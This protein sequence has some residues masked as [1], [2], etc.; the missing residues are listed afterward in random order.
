MSPANKLK[1]C[2]RSFDWRKS[3]AHLALLAWFVDPRPPDN[4][5]TNTNWNLVLGEPSDVAVE[6]FVRDKA[7][8]ACGTTQ[9]LL[10]ELPKLPSSRL[11][12]LLI[13][14]GLSTSGTKQEKV[15]R[16]TQKFDPGLLYEVPERYLLQC[17]DEGLQ[18][19]ERFLEKGAEA[20][21]GADKR[22]LEAV[23]GILIWLLKDAILAGVI[24]AAAYD[25]IK[26]LFPDEEIPRP[27]IP[28]PTEIPTD[29]PSP[30]PVPEP[31]E[32]T[33]LPERTPARERDRRPMR[34]TDRFIEPEIVR[35]PAGYFWMGSDHNDADAW[36]DEK[37]RHRLYLP[38]FWIGRCPVTVAEFAAFI[39]DRGYKTTAE[40]RDS[41]Y[42]WQH[43]RGPAS[44]VR[45][46]GDR[47]VTQVSWYD[48]L[49]Y[50]RWLSDLTGTHYTLPSEAEWEKA[51]RGTDR[52][53]YPWGNV[54]DK[55]RCN[56]WEGGKIDTTPGGHYSP[57]GDSPYGCADMAGNVWE[58]TRSLWGKG[59]GKPEFGY[60]YNPKDGREDLDAPQDVLRVLRGGSFNNNER[61]A[62]CAYR[63]DN[64]INNLNNNIGFRVVA[65]HVFPFFRGK[66]LKVLR[67]LGFFHERME[68]HGTPPHENRC[69]C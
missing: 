24:G 2:N 11:S 1:P 43:P 4:Y 53:I 44:D 12:E 25:L 63:N 28:A 52:R 40:Q 19:V 26:K 22:T 42:T 46:K 8:R 34:R 45:G 36:E 37:P 33:P 51:A 14:R 29:A 7:L 60:P 48:A 32:S 41:H 5:P 16:L 15:R 30:E 68:R 38:E 31:S 39:R 57:R 65:S 27:S 20:L 62:R 9:I 10:H 21:E 49:A 13:E 50:C 69:C 55:S 3:P 67:P 6:R 61:N 66:T 64:D 47:P 23:K 58:W 56:S 59:W 17:S 54:W 18:I 35:V